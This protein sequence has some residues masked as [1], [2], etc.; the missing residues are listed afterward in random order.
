MYRYLVCGRWGRHKRSFAISAVN[1]DDAIEV[2]DELV[3]FYAS[4]TENYTTQTW[5]YGEIT[6]EPVEAEEARLLLRGERAFLR[7]IR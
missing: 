2:A 4:G 1:L 5:R 3:K 7:L 6:V